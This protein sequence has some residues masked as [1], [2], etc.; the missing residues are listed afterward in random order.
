MNKRGQ[1]F[2]VAALIVVAIVIGLATVYTSVQTGRE[3]PTVE[4]LSKEIS[5]EG[6]QVIDYG[7][8]QGQNP[9]EIEDFLNELGQTYAEIHPES[10]ITIIYFNEDM[11]GGGTG[12]SYSESLIGSVGIGDAKQ[13]ITAFQREDIN[14]FVIDENTIG[15]EINNRTYEFDTREGQN[16][17]I[18]VTQE[19]AEETFVGKQP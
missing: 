3:E 10:Q 19:G 15:A 6:A 12:S 18:V 16:F 2:L 5:F 7:V 1:F 9:E 11:I 13:E 17:F 8:F 4:S 14:L